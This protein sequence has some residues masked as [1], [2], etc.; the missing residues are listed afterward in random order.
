[1]PR[2]IKQQRL[3]TIFGTPCSWMYKDEKRGDS[4]E[5]KVVSFLRNRETAGERERVTAGRRACE[6]H[7]HTVMSTELVTPCQPLHHEQ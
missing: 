1:M 4:E 7:Q 2:R 6:R 3:L 5:E